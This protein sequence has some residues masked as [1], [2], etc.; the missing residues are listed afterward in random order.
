MGTKGNKLTIDSIQRAERFKDKIDSIGG[1]STKK[2]FGGHGVFWNGKMFGIVD[3]KGHCY[4]KANEQNQPDFDQ[5]G[6]Q[7]H[8]KMPYFSIP[9]SVFNDPKELLTLANKSLP[10]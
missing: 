1:I 10:Y 9:D 6:S 4:L 3:S 2:M 8:G 7:Q 5:Y